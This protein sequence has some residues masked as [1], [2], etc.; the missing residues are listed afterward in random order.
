MKT[1][2]MLALLVLAALLLP[3]VPLAEADFTIQGYISPRLVEYDKPV[4]ATV[5]HQGGK[6]PIQYNFTWMIYEGDAGH[7]VLYETNTTGVSTLQRPFGEAG[8]VIVRA[9][10][11]DGRWAVYEDISFTVTGATPNPINCWVMFYQQ[12]VNVGEELMGYVHSTG[13]V[14]PFTYYYYWEIMESG[15]THIWKNVQSGEDTDVQAPPYGDTAI[16]YVR[17]KD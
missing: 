10:D 8:N 17:V 7:Y 4:T 16:L 11:A 15:Q 3:L 9:M 12:T 13:G 2:R 5:L 6:E 14:P 1:R